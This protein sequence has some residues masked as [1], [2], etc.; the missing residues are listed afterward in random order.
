MS[1]IIIFILLGI[2]AG[3]GYLIYKVVVNLLRRTRSTGPDNSMGDSNLLRNIRI[4]S[5]ILSAGILI[6][7][8]VLPMAH[9][10]QFFPMLIIVFSGIG[11]GETN[12]LASLS[13]LYFLIPLLMLVANFVA[14]PRAMKLLSVLLFIPLVTIFLSVP[15]MDT[16]GNN[17]GDIR[18]FGIGTLLYISMAIGQTLLWS[19]CIRR[20][21]LSATETAGI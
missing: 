2:I 17:W 20:S 16:T 8:S 19:A 10:F 3:V 21:Q 12:I 1:F 5:A 18:L 4:Y 11:A 6:A 9:K 7:I 13:A 15:L 14:N